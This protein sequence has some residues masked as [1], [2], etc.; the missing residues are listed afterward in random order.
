MKEKSVRRLSEAEAIQT[1]H[2]VSPEPDVYLLPGALIKVMV[3]Q[4]Q[5]TMLGENIPQDT[6]VTA[7]PFQYQDG[8][9]MYLLKAKAN[10][11]VVEEQL[12]TL[13]SSPPIHEL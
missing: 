13:G 7:A 3:D 9:K 10:I 6:Y 5:I 11:L 2:L 12:E 1:L 8:Q 4:L